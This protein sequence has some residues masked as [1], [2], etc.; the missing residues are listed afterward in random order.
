[1]KASGFIRNKRSGFAQVSNTCLR[2]PSLSLTAKGLYSLIQSLITNTD[3]K[4]FKSS[5]QRDF[6]KEGR[7]AFNT[8]WKELI[9]AG[10]LKMY[11]INT[12]DGFIYEYEL[13]DE[14]EKGK[15]QS[16]KGGN[17]SKAPE[18]EVK[19]SKNEE[20]YIDSPD[21]DFPHL[22]NPHL[23]DPHL[24][25]PGLE[26]P[27]LLNNTLLSNTNKI[28]KKNKR[29]TSEVDDP[30]LLPPTDF[31]SLRQGGLPVSEPDRKIIAYLSEQ[32]HFSDELA[33][34][35]ID[36]ALKKCND[37]LN[38]NYISKVASTWIRKGIDT[39]QKA[40]DFLSNNDQKASKPKKS[41]YVPKQM[42]EIPMPAYWNNRDNFNRESISDEKLKELQELQLE[43][44]E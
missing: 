30:F 21:T 32:M 7:D 17:Q 27:S 44:A 22:G 13:L 37:M 31:L 18:S 24:G 34:V 14:P 2:D 10:F 25:S 38:S 33:N 9:K 11:K 5:L 19:A 41:S 43:M 42:Q 12:T 15:E 40:L 26:N 36:H 28:N 39:R 4:L 23:D 8:A 16:G 20:K 6:C 1:M 3:Y 29:A 35:L